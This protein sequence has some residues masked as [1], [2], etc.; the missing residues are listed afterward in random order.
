MFAIISF[1][2]AKESFSSIDSVVSMVD[3]FGSLS[4]A[5]DE[6]KNGWEILKASISAVESVLSSIST[7]MATV[8]AIQDLFNITSTK[9]V[10]AKT[11][12]V[13][14]IVEVDVEYWWCFRVCWSEKL[15]LF[16]IARVYVRNILKC[17]IL[18]LVIIKNYSYRDITVII[19]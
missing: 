13:G 14:A 6:N 18:Y 17:I 11:A 5:I 16:Y 2:E 1:I 19:R 7:V 3:A 8:N 15:H 9:T 10:A 4:S 12:E